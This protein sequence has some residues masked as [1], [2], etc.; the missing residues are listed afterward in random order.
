MLEPVCFFP[1]ANILRLIFLDGLHHKKVSLPVFNMRNLDMSV[2]WIYCIIDVCMF[3]SDATDR[4]SE[5]SAPAQMEETDATEEG[6][7]GQR[8]RL[9][10]ER[11]LPGRAAEVRG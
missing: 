8:C 9:S 7:G 6:S 10:P 1:A 2:L 4:L 5:Q 11:T 3:A